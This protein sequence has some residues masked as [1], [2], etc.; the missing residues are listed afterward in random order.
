MKD[1]IMQL[2]DTVRETGFAIHRYHRHGH[3][4]KFY[5]IPHTTGFNYIEPS[6][7]NAIAS[8]TR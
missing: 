5:G 7:D 3:V 1:S 8:A 6:E 2:C 4:E